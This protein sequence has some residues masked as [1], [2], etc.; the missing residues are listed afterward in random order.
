MESTLSILPSDPRHA[1]LWYDWRQDPGAKK[2]NPFA[3]STVE[4]L[5]ERLLKASS[6][7]ALFDRVDNFIWL[8]KAENE[9]VGNMNLH[10]INKTMLTAEIG[11]MIS[12]RARGKGFATFSVQYLTQMC[13]EKTPLRKLIAYVH[14]DNL[15]SRRVLEK[16]GYEAEGLLRE[17][18]LIDGQPVNE[19]IY[20]IL[21]RDWNESQG[22]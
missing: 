14:E 7:I 3:P 8:L 21:L 13:F 19:V 12:P 2:Y 17:H 6:D 15:P 18:Y 4:T 11:Y 22:S 5:R 9:V 16:A 1:E 20:G 10:N